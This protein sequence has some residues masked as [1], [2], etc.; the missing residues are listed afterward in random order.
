V[1]LPVQEPNLEFVH[2]G[3]RRPAV[4]AIFVPKKKIDGTTP[5]ICAQW[6]SGFIFLRYDLPHETNSRLAAAHDILSP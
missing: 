4:G 3:C 5:R 6:D 2:N 1:S